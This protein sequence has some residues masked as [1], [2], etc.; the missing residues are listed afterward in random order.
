MLP[1]QWQKKIVDMNVAQLKDSDLAWAD[2]VFVSGM[3]IQRDSIK[4]VLERCRKF[5]C[6][7]VAGG[8]IFTTG[9]EEFA[10]GV[11]HF[12]INEGEVTIPLFLN[13]LM[14]GSPKKMYT[15]TERPDI[16]KTPIP[17]WR[18][19]NFKDYATMAIQYSRGCPFDCEFCDITI[20]NGRNPRT[21]TNGQLVAELEALY[22]Q[23]WRGSVFIVD[24]NFIG[25]KNRVREALPSVI[26]W[27]HKRRNP[28]TFLTE[29]SVNLADDPELMQ[30]M[31]KAGF[32]KVF[33]GLET[34]IA[35]NLAEC[36]KF[37]NAKR[38]LVD[39]VKDIQN[40]GL[41][42]MAGFIVGFDNDPASIFERQIEFI[43][44]SG[45]VTAMVSLLGALP[46]TRLY[47]RLKKEGRLLKKWTGDNTECSINFI[48]RMDI[49][50]LKVGYK[51]IV[52][53]IYHPSR[54]YERVMTFIKEFKPHKAVFKSHLSREQLLA[55]VRSLWY[56]GVV[57]RFRKFYWK[58]LFRTLFRNPRVFPQ[59][60]I[61]AIYGYH[62]QKLS[63]ELQ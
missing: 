55:F 53:T 7:V 54:Y 20:M 27:M 19:I 49:N 13:D 41:E 34:P 12:V 11:D 14:Q 46:G 3:I 60:V 21:K 9:Y 61:F 56:L 51:K 59:A 45:V 57:W 31:V 22:E 33:I 44:K 58:L 62:F 47:L 25:N 43:Q 42:V 23:G 52:K 35:E 5:N 37:I 28:F 8:P 40:S 2:Y 48:P 15:S 26:D 24:D 50:T 29:A 38:N 32:H 4:S 39:A 17:L 63:E 1:V 6:K 30:M 10:Q 18:L 36:N 16:A